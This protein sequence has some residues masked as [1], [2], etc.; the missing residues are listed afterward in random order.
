[1]YLQAADGLLDGVETLL[2]VGSVDVVTTFRTSFD[3][4]FGQQ[5]IPG[6]AALI[7]AP[8]QTFDRMQLWVREDQLLYGPNSAQAQPFR[9]ADDIL[10]RVVQT[11][12]RSD[13]VALPFYPL[14]EQIRKAAAQ[15]DHESW[16]IANANLV[17]LYQTLA[18][19]PDLIPMQVDALMERYTTEIKQLR[20]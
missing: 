15:P 20:R 12:E 8:E 18:Q 17:T 11:A 5:F 4:T 7:E 14:L 3:P 1:S 10:Y 13:E 16:Q 19:S 2:Q 9:Q 6:Y